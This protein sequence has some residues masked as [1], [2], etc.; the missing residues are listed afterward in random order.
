MTAVSRANISIN[1]MY[2]TF[3]RDGAAPIIVIQ[4]DD[5]PELES[6]LL[7]SGVKVR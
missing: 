4:A 5:M 1:Y 2:A 7:Y 3:D 6:Y